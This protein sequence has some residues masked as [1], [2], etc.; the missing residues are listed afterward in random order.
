MVSN[1]EKNE[2]VL[3]TH[4]PLTRVAVGKV[5]DIYS[6]GADKL[7]IVTTDRLS[8]FDVVMPNPIPLKGK[9]S[10]RSRSSGRIISKT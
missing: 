1:L 8:A 4:L 10:T 5:R 6:V 3:E 2:A 9:V 7:L